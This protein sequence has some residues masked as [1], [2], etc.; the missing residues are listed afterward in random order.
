MDSQERIHVMNTKFDSDD[1]L[2]LDNILSLDNMTIVITSVILNYLQLFTL[3]TLS[4]IIYNIML[5]TI[6]LDECLYEL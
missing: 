6:Y 2:P 4:T 5:S 1:D 3:S